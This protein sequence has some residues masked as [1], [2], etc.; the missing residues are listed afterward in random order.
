MSDHASLSPSKAH[1]WVACPGSIREEQKYPDST[2]PAAID[3]THS[4]TLLENCI[5]MGLIDP[6]NFVGQELED[7]EGKF[8]VDKERAQ[9]VKIAIDYLKD[10]GQELGDHKIISERR[11]NPERFFGRDDCSGTVDIQIIGSDILEIIDYKDGMNAVA[12]KDNEQLEIYALGV[13]SELGLP[14]NGAYPY[15]KV[16]MTVIQP[17]VQFRGGIAIS[18]TEM[19]IDEILGKIGKYVV[20]AKATDNIEAPLVPG[21]SQCKYCRAKGG[22][23]ALA[24]NVMK[25]VGVMFQSLDIAQQSADK[26]PNTMSD[27]QLREIVEAAPLMR[28]LLDSAEAEAQRRMEAGKTI[29]GLK[30]VHGRGSKSWS[31]PEDQ[32]AD[33]LVKMGIPK[34][35]VYKTTMISPAQALKVTWEKRDGTKKQLSER[36][37][38]TLE[39]EY[40]AKSQG[41]LTVVSESDSRPAVQLNAEKL[42]SAVPETVDVPSWLS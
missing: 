13:L 15:R 25:E 1:R 11:V 22:C 20:A 26:D 5:N 3:G 19:T 12:V 16:R 2:G 18:S 30:L 8:V 29:A 39:Q 27:E 33:K 31:L 28:Q 35:S 24:G 6:V 36:Q 41:K 37:L 7:H 23:S 40:I 9:R 10:R 4:H 34:S 38:K 32:M 42:F 21:E 17:K 14:V